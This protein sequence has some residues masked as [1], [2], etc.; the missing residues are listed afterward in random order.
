[1]K[2]VL[3][4]FLSLAVTTSALAGGVG[5]LSALE[6]VGNL[7]KNGNAN[8]TAGIIN[9]SQIKANAT[10]KGKDS[11]AMAGGVVSATPSGD[12]AKMKITAG[13]IGDSTINATAK[14]QDGGKA[15]AG[16]VVS[17]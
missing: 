1:M 12:G 8:V 5:A 11:E 6:A 17:K 9:N 16:G 13:Y 10:A 7:S 15:Y 4:S 2:K 14:A 3:V